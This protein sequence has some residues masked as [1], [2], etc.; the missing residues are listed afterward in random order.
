MYFI[1]CKLRILEIFCYVLLRMLIK[2]LL[3]TTHHIMHRNIFLTVLLYSLSIIKYPLMKILLEK[4]S[5]ALG[6]FSVCL[7]LLLSSKWVTPTFEATRYTV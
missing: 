3:K 1:I 5:K 6:C 7:F 4:P 2:Q